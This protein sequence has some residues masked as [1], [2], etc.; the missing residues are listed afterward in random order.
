MYTSC[1]V[2]ICA[3]S[4]SAVDSTRRFRDER[5][6]I[7]NWMWLPIWTDYIASDGAKNPTPFVCVR[8]ATASKGAACGTE[9]LVIFICWPGIRHPKEAH[10]MF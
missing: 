6:D 9:E 3:A 5:T 8:V 7:Q 2:M 10:M 4:Y 1:G